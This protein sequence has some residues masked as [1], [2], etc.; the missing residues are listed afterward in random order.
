MFTV[1]LAAL[2]SQ[3][4][5][6]QLADGGVYHLDT[7]RLLTDNTQELQGFKVLSGGGES[8]GDFYSVGRLILHGP[9]LGDYGTQLVINGDRFTDDSQANV[10]LG[11]NRRRPR[12]ALG[13]NAT[14]LEL[15]RGPDHADQAWVMDSAGYLVAICNDA[16]SGSE[17]GC[18]LVDSTGV[19]GHPFVQGGKG[20]HLVVMGRIGENL[21]GRHLDGGDEVLPYAGLHGELTVVPSIHREVGWIQQWA[22][23][24]HTDGGW[25]RNE[26]AF[27][28]AQMGIGTRH[29]W[30]Y[31]EFR[32]PDEFELTT[33]G[34]FHPGGALE[35]TLQFAGNETGYGAH[36]WHVKQANGGPLDG[37]WQEIPY[38][39]ETVTPAQL[40]STKW[41]LNSKINSLSARLAD[42]GL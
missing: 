19:S 42:A 32:G 29:W 38:A 33:I 4:V 2:L 41:W 13:T 5:D 8:I 20:Y 18:A 11:G 6:L 1:I 30:N 21:D 36:H 17:G 7:S 34:Q 10:V 12:G 31:D 14:E 9:L 16:S 27:I 23:G 35:S 28:D 3:T 40:G 25:D 26:W 22:N 37:G 15:R 24:G 39:S